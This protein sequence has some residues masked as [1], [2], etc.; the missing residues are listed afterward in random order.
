MI[1][2]RCGHCCKAYMVVIVDDPEK[3]IDEDNLICNDGSN[4]CKHLQGNSPGK[5]SCAIHDMS[6]YK[7]TP[8]FQHGQIEQS[9]N[10][11]CRLGEFMLK[12]IQLKKK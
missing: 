1:C 8:C 9:P 7:K 11:P 4:Q 5:Y 6:W 2:L 12:R 10:D 3:G